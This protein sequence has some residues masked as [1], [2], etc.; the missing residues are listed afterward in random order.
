MCGILA[1]KRIRAS[2]GAL[3][4]LRVAIAG[5]VLATGLTVA[6]G[7]H[8]Y[9]WADNRRRGVQEG[10]RVV[11]EFIAYVSRGLYDDAAARLSAQARTEWRQAQLV[12]MKQALDT[13]G[14]MQSLDVTHTYW[15]RWRALD[16]AVELYL[17]V[18]FEKHEWKIK[19]TMG[20][21]GGQ[22]LIE[23]IQGQSSG[24]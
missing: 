8:L 4:G 17:T 22:W 2:K 15:R 19:V 14:K 12:R 16:Q 3:V 20:Q 5:L 11:R 10:Q 7:V 9:R 1:I 21:Y 6:L 18:T 23:S 13:W 24:G